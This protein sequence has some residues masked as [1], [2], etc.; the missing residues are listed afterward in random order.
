ME[1]SLFRFFVTKIKPD[2]FTSVDC[3]NENKYL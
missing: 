2:I 3:K 1:K